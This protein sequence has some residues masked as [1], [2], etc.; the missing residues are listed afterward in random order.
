VSNKGNISIVLNNSTVS[1]LDVHHDFCDNQQEE[2]Q[3]DD[4]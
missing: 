3:K 2:D 1:T 4:D